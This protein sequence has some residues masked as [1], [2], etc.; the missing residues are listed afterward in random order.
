MELFFQAFIPLFVAIDVLGVLPLFVGLTE[1]MDD[2]SRRTLTAEA[3][4]INGLKA[5]KKTDNDDSPRHGQASATAANNT[6]QRPAGRN[7]RRHQ[8]LRLVLSTGIPHTYPR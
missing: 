6:N 8:N 4:A 3:T 5:G 7:L 1:K 2:R